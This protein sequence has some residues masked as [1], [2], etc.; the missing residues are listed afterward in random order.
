ML[1]L[2]RSKFFAEALRFIL[3][4]LV[5]EVRVIDSWDDLEHL[6]SRGK[7]NVVVCDISCVE[8]SGEQNFRNIK[9]ISPD[10]KVVVFSFDPPGKHRDF[11][12]KIGADGYIN[13]P[14]NPS[15]VLD[16]FKDLD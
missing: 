10:S 7:Y 16:S 6:L 1:I 15:A 8:D 9:S 12:A 14:L 2:S 11:V 4:D 5:G 3:H 13:R